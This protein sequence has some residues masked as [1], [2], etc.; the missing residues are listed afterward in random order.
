MAK[1]IHNLKHDTTL[2]SSILS[3]IDVPP[4]SQILRTKYPD[5]TDNFVQR[6]NSLHQADRGNEITTLLKQ[7]QAFEITYNESSLRLSLEEKNLV[8]GFFSNYLENLYELAFNI[9]KHQVLIQG[10]TDAFT[11][12]HSCHYILLLEALINDLSPNPFIEVEKAKSKV[13]TFYQGQISH[14]VIKNELEIANN[15]KNDIEA[16]R[17]QIGSPESM[18]RGLIIIFMRGL[19]DAAFSCQKLYEEHDIANRNLLQV[20]NSAIKE[21]KQ[22]YPELAKA[23][24]KLHEAIANQPIP[25]G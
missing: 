20:I 22:S 17:S 13:S 6:L 3:F 1:E 25:K 8:E 4:L 23:G 19:C 12:N 15:L 11:L 14:T 16:I 2:A 24:E 10:T 21:L 18:P 9:R 5:E 7:L